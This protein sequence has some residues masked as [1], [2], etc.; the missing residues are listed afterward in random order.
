M[1]IL[2]EDTVGNANDYVDEVL[3]NLR[4]EP[5]IISK[6][7]PLDIPEVNEKNFELKEGKIRGLSSLYRHGDCT[8]DYDGEI[9]KVSAQVAVRD[10]FVELKYAAKALFFWIKV[11]PMKKDVAEFRLATNHD[12]LARH[13]HLIKVLNNPCCM[14]CDFQE[15]MDCA[16]L[17]PCPLL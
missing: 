4:K 6:I 12:S 2:L 7:D 11:W 14:L 9:V 8:L 16:H 3:K 5:W 13:L 15:P 17:L 10:V 1:Y